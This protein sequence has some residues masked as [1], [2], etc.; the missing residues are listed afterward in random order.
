M[1]TS[2]GFSW[3]E[4]S[5]AH[6]FEWSEETMPLCTSCQP[7]QYKLNGCTNCPEGYY[8]STLLEAQRPECQVCIPGFYQ[9]KKASTSCKQC[10]VGY[11]IDRTAATQCAACAAGQYQINTAKTFCTICPVGF[12]QASPGQ[13]DCTECPEGKFNDAT[14]ATKCKDC[15][16]GKYSGSS[17]RKYRL[18]KGRYASQHGRISQCTQ[19]SSGQ[20]QTATGQES[21]VQCQVAKYSDQDGQVGCKDCPSGFYQ[22][23]VAQDKCVA[24]TGG[25]TCSASEQG[26][27]CSD[28]YVVCS[29]LVVRCN[30]CEETSSNSLRTECEDCPAGRTTFTKSG[31][32]CEQCPSNGNID[33]VDGLS[34]LKVWKSWF[35]S[36]RKQ[37][38]YWTAAKAPFDFQSIKKTVQTRDQKFSFKQLRRRTNSIMP[39]Y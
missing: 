5:K 32:V 36:R 34:T 19:C 14:T 10:P 2:S 22:N 18:C 23:K 26:S 29:D 33:Y 20:Y 21:C 16:P 35:V 7:G 17:C 4:K 13:R 37:V 31:A 30:A 15:L 28:G 6:V 8:T 11:I 3:Y 1:S 38:L 9:N 25:A 12:Y 24:C 39:F 27:E